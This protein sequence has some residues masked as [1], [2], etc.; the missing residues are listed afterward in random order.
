MFGCPLPLPDEDGMA[1]VG[2]RRAGLPKTVVFG[3]TSW[4]T[5]EFAPT[6]LFAP[7]RTSPAMQADL[8]R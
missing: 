3:G 7:T 5:T 1:V 2:A 6:R 8:R 4:V